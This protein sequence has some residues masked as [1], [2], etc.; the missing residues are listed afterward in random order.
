MADKQ[1]SGGLLGGLTDTVGGAAQGLT[2]TVGNTVG[3]V[4]QGVGMFSSSHTPHL[5]HISTP[6]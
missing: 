3:G 6:Y 5:S 4:G 2:S 1:G